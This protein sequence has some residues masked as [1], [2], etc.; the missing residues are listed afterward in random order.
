M[1]VNP[2]TLLARLGLGFSHA[3]LN[4]LGIIPVMPGRAFLD[5]LKVHIYAAL[6]NLAQHSTV[7]NLL[8]PFN[9]HVFASHQFTQPG[10]AFGTEGLLLLR[11][12]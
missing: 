2:S 12:V 1:R 4:R 6:D 3:Q 9:N 5:Y 7:G 11:C 8:F 10:F